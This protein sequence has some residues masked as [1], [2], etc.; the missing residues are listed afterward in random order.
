M[1]EKSSSTYTTIDFTLEV[2]DRMHLASVL[3]RLRRIPEV[4]RIAR[5]K[6]RKLNQPHP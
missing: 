3:K 5:L 4:V 1:G 2:R 6:H